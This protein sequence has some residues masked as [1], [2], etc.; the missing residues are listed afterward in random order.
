MSTYKI[1]FR[2]RPPS[3]EV[4][5]E[6]HTVKEQGP[7]YIF[8]DVNQNVVAVFPTEEVLS[9]IPEAESEPIA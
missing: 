5:I 4:S 6:A 7:S 9:I 3:S 8:L 1:K 2:N